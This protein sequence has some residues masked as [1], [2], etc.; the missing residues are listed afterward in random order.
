MKKHFK[1]AAAVLASTGTIGLVNATPANAAACLAAGPISSYT[2]GVPCTQGA[3]TFTLNSFNGFAANDM[4]SLSNTSS[5][6]SLG[7]LADNPW[8]PGAY[9]VNYTIKAAPTKLL[10][11]Y[12]S[13]LT[14][15][16]N[17]GMPVV[18]AGTWD[19]NG[20]NGI[21]AATFST[22]TANNG[23]KNYVPKINSDTFTSTLNVT[24]GV[25]QSVTSTV[26]VVNAP[27]VTPVPGPLPLL[28]A[29]AAFGF[30]RK[31]RKSIKAAA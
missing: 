30:S 13:S 14:S 21:A 31:L 1:L 9:D 18:D 29:G 10:N 2:L 20:A 15:S 8:G 23:N 7:V 25:I 16:V 28:G 12:T 5:F 27:P 24:S 26:N 3:F 6:M 11:N 4:L 19:V 17:D 22:P